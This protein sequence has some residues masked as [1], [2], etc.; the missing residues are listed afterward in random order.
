MRLTL[1]GGVGTAKLAIADTA[2][3]TMTTAST[4]PSTMRAL[5]LQRV[6][7]SLRVVRGV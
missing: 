3:V 4:M 1:S 2:N 6:I 7:D 5:R